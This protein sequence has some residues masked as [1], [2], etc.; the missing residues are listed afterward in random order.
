MVVVVVDLF[1]WRRKQLKLTMYNSSRGSDGRNRSPFCESWPKIELLPTKWK[2]W[3][4]LH[5]CSARTATLTG[6]CDLRSG[7]STQ[8]QK[9]KQAHYHYDTASRPAIW[10]VLNGREWPASYHERTTNPGMLADLRIYIQVP[11]CKWWGRGR[12]R[13]SHAGLPDGLAFR[14]TRVP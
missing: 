9:Q 3:P 1:W 10:G 11:Y 12:S 2:R 4:Q 5:A 7:I 6:C 13:G 14:P 8:K